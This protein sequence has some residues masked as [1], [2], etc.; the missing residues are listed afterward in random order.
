[1]LVTPGRPGNPSRLHAAHRGPRVLVPNV[2]EFIELAADDSESH[3]PA[4]AN[5][6]VVAVHHR[7]AGQGADA[8]VHMVEHEFL[9]E[10]E[11]DAA[12]CTTQD[13]LASK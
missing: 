5:Y 3:Y 6:K 1:M 7:A 11:V 12:I 9:R 2:G 13:T 10:A 4:I 8:L